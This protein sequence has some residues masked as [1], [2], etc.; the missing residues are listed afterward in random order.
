MRPNTILAFLTLKLYFGY[1]RLENET[2]DIIESNLE[3]LQ[4]EIGRNIALQEIPPKEKHW[5]RTWLDHIFE[6][7]HRWNLKVERNTNFLSKI[8]KN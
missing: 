2:N 5:N 1:T 6:L 3:K 7:C 4:V 8:T